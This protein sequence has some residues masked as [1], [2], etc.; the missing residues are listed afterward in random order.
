M[1]EDHMMCRTVIAM[2][3]AAML[4]P[5]CARAQ[6]RELAAQL[7]R[8][9]AFVKQQAGDSI[10]AMYEAEGALH[11]PGRDPIRGPAAIARFLA[12]F[13]NVRVD[14]SAMW[15][16]SVVRTD[17][18]IAQWGGYFQIA[19]PSG[20]APVTARGHFVAVWARQPD[21]RWLLRSM[22]TY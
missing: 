16:D 12:G 3:L 15:A 2:A 20:R 7:A 18:G 10:A 19:T 9:N 21:G 22:R 5:S 13:T 11:A 6:D 14:S 17:S 8:Y 4:A 1:H